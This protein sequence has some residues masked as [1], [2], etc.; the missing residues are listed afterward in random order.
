MLTHWIFKA[1]FQEHLALICKHIY[2]KKLQENSCLLRKL[3][4]AFLMHMLE[5]LRKSMRRKVKR[6]KPA[7][8]KVLLV[9]GKLVYKACTNTP[10]VTIISLCNTQREQY[11]HCY[12]LNTT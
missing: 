11:V 9:T 6:Q 4:Q 5:S 2:L 12:T 10:G 8:S 3:W 7:D 1:F